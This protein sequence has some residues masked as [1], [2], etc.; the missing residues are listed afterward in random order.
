MILEGSHC[1]AIPIVN[2]LRPNM[3]G[4]KYLRKSLLYVVLEI[5][6]ENLQFA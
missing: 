6:L 1:I 2:T 5:K 4:I 3:E